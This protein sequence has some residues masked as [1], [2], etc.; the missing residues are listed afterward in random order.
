MVPIGQRRIKVDKV[1]QL[2]G[3]TGPIAV[4]YEDLHTVPSDF[5]AGQT[6]SI[7][8]P[9]G[10]TAMSFKPPTCTIPTRASLSHA[11]AS[12]AQGT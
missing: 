1:V 12:D 9:V 5:N 2:S 4:E 7:L 11:A 10:N 8:V 3:K 6:H